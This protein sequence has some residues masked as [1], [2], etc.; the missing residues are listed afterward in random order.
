MTLLDAPQFDPAKIR[1]R[2]I[3]IVTAI[4]GVI[5]LLV[6]GWMYRNWPEE[7]VADKFFAA[8]QRQDFETAYGIYFHDPDWQQ[9][10]Q[11]YAQYTYADFYQDWGPGGEWGLIKSHRV[12]ASVATKEGVVVEVVV[13]ERAEPARMFV[14]KSDKTLTVY[15]Y[16]LVR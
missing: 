3:R 1:R 13:N 10:K 16:A 7:H 2:N 15:P 5:V 14:S 12:D 4:V 11:K 8:L 6:L 9:H